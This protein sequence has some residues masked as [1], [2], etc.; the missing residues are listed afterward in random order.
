MSTATTTAACSP[1]IPTATPLV[2]T[3]R[4]RCMD[5]DTKREYDS[6]IAGGTTPMS[7][8]ELAAAGAKLGYTLKSSSHTYHNTLNAGRSW[9]AASFTWIDSRTGHRFSH[10]QADTTNLAALQELRRSATVIHRG[11]LVEC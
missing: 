4:T 8:T 9:A 11:R 7:I 6:Q 10:V 1:Q 5:G 2:R 3:P